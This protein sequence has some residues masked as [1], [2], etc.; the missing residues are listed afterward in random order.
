VLWLVP[1]RTMRATA[2]E[3]LLPVTTQ[4][5]SCSSWNF[6]WRWALVDSYIASV[7]VGSLV[8]ALRR[9]VRSC[10]IAIARLARPR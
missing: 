7:V 4:R 3:C 2:A 5:M 9:R 6:G 10:S 1:A 8:A